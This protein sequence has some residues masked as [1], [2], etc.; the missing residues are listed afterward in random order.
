MQKQNPY[1]E[2]HENNERKQRD[3]NKAVGWVER[4]DCVVLSVKTSPSPVSYDTVSERN[5]SP[6]WMSDTST[7]HTK[8]PFGS[9][10]LKVRLTGGREAGT[11][12]FL[13]SFPSQP[14][15]TRVFKI[16]DSRLIRIYVNR[17]GLTVGTMR[18]RAPYTTPH[19]AIKMR[20]QI[21]HPG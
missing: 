17:I 16:L 8:V 15:G 5:P 1:H 19:A 21:I 6:F 20:Y 4:R 2:I 12:R 13:G 9:S 10:Q 11:H 14:P 7:K 18:L 3:K